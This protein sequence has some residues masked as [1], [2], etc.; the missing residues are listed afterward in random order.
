MVT[1]K[2]ETMNEPR[3]RLTVRDR[4]ISSGTTDVSDPY[5]Y[6]T[7]SRLRRRF[8]RLRAGIAVLEHHDMLADE[9]R[10]VVYNE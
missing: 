5:R 9:L 2:T 1:Q 7:H 6:Q 8:D 3:A 4:E 10:E